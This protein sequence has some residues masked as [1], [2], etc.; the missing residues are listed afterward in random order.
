MAKNVINSE[1]PS[2]LTCPTCKTPF[3]HQNSVWSCEACGYK[4]EDEDV[5]NGIEEI[6]TAFKKKSDNVAETKKTEKDAKTKYRERMAALKAKRTG[7][8]VPV[9]GSSNEDIFANGVVPNMNAV[10]QKQLVE[11]VMK[12]L[13]KKD[14]LEKIMKMMGIDNQALSNICKNTP[15]QQ[16]ASGKK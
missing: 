4:L 5:R 3:K 11:L 6:V 12:N 15:L 2:A 16:F 13:N 14:E 8:F 10:S 1:V 7:Q 9:N